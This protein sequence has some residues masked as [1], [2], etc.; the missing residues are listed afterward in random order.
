MAPNTPLKDITL[1]G[2]GPGSF[3]QLS[4]GA[5]EALQQAEAL[6]LRTVVHPTVAEIAA[7]GVQF[8]SFDRL[9]ESVESFAA[10]YEQIAGSVLTAAGSGPV[11]YAV[12]GHPLVGETSVQLIIK[13][14]RSQGLSVAI[15]PSMSALDAVFAAAEL[16]PSRGLQVCDALDFNPRLFLTTQPALFLQLHSRL[17]ASQLKLALLGLYDPDHEVL[18]IRGA[19]IP[20]QERLW[21]LPLHE[22][23]R[24]ERIDHLTSLYIPPAPPTDPPPGAHP[25]DPLTSVM[26]QLLGDDG[27]PW[28]RQQTHQSLK[29]YLIEETYEVI[30]AIDAG[31]PEALCEELG[32]VLLQ[33]VFHAQLASMRGAFDIDDVVKTITAKM[34]R[35]HPHVFAGT[36]VADAE[37]VLENWE[38]IK[39]TEKAGQEVAGLLGSVPRHLPALMLAEVLQKR[40][41]KVGF[42]W[43]D[44]DGALVK[45]EEEIRELKTAT[46]S[47]PLAE[48][49]AELGDVLFTVA[50][51]ARYLGI[52][53]E[54]AL[55][56]TASKFCRRFRHIEKRAAM[57]GRALEE[58]TLNEMDAYWE[59]AKA[60][61]RSASTTKGEA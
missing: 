25:L 35:R 29:R 34:R 15:V 42:Q 17:A 24:E 41:A 32:D 22:L 4:V 59:E 31:D 37:A 58:M 30:D 9:Y 3:A 46:S 11:T 60:K 44:V 38:A 10:L 52:D 33:V 53:P 12:P 7:R 5:W 49:A 23:D 20:E 6:Y 19:G 43:D 56:A 39:R 50:N 47:A 55:R 2:L 14:A 1:V 40:A 16:D 36:Q 51:V 54:A 48:Q 57:A 21:Y 27:C 61:E 26:Q 13:A 28:D 45:V 8:R 18:L